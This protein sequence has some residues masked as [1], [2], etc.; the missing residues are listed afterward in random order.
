MTSFGLDE[1]DEVHEIEF[2]ALL[3]FLARERQRLKS[4]NDPN[5]KFTGADLQMAYAFKNHFG[6]QKPA[7]AS[8][9]QVA[10]GVQPPVQTKLAYATP[11]RDQSARF[12]TSSAPPQGYASKVPL[13]N[14]NPQL[15][16]QR[17][18]GDSQIYP[19]DSSLYGQS[20]MSQ[21]SGNP[22]LAG[23]RSSGSGLISPIA[24]QLPSG[25]RSKPPSQ[26]DFSEIGQPLAQFPQL[27][28]E[29]SPLGKES[30]SVDIGKMKYMP[31]NTSLFPPCSVP[32]AKWA[33]AARRRPVGRP[34]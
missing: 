1:R 2:L 29:R 11:L 12:R 17:K 22:P 34:P 31:R 25:F 13:R 19:R 5:N 27:S 28:P 14:P 23:Q 24:Q 10:P 16:Q 20:R 30:Y 32:A 9:N 21:A 26:H 33:E 8:N 3:A 7:Q 18:Q 15:L 6:G 4:S